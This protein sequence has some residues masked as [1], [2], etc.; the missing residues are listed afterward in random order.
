MF[1]I[2][3]MKDEVVRGFVETRLV[4]RDKFLLK[5]EIFTN[6]V[7]EGIFLKKGIFW[8]LIQTAQNSFYWS[9]QVTLTVIAQMIKNET[10]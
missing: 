10:I 3:N 5:T 7:C 1:H 9:G 6:I 4:M 8:D 2:N